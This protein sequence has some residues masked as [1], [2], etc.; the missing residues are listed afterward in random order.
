MVL[1]I[2]SLETD[3]PGLDPTS[4]NFMLGAIEQVT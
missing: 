2:W 4:V 3:G 1:R